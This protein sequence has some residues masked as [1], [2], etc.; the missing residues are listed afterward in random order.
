MLLRPSV[1][2]G[3]AGLPPPSACSPAFSPS[4]LLT[5]EAGASI[6]RPRRSRVPAKMP[7]KWRRSSPLGQEKWRRVRYGRTLATPTSAVQIK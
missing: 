4:H 1:S 5:E 6:E 3:E 2:G 7:A